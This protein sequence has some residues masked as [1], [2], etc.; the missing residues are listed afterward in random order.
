MQNAKELIKMID[1]INTNDGKRYWI[2][3]LNC[4]DATKGYL[5]DHFGLLD[6]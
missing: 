1:L 3:A 2:N 4:N 6:A 5:L